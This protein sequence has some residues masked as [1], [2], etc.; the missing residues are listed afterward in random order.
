MIKSI[1][2]I[3]LN[4]FFA[5]CEEN[6]DPSL[7]SKPVAVGSDHKRGIVSTA[8]YAARKFGVHS[9]MPMYLAKK[10]CPNL[11]IVE[12]HYSLYSSV[13][14]RFMSYLKKKYPILEQVSVD[15]CYIDMSGIIND[16]NA[17]DYLADL[18]LKIYM[19]LKLKCSIGYA[20]TKFLAK[21]ASDYK[22]P[23]GLTL[24]VKDDYKKLFWPMT[25]D[26]M[27]GIGKSSAP[28]LVQLGINTIGDLANNTSKEVEDLLGINYDTFYMWA[29]GE[30]SNKVN[31]DYE[32]RK[33][34]STST[35]LLDDS[36]DVLLLK[37]TLRML[38]GD[39]AS[40][41]KSES[42]R[43]KKVVVTIRNKLFQTHSKRS[44]LEDYTDDFEKIYLKVIAIFD[45]FYKGEEVRLLG[46]GVE[47]FAAKIKDDENVSLFQVSKEEKKEDSILSNLNT[48]KTKGLFTTLGD[49]SKGS[50]K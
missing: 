29:N 31:S 17:H 35:T 2:H 36:D 21:M 30:G 44:D 13:S 45:G 48:G 24:V 33:S 40:Q 10:K 6:R 46:V 23:M 39:I 42:K 1:V 34:I 20:H 8:N 37:D 16:T 19:D 9:A 12:G 26:K 38:T 5:Q 25:I 27:W 7:K 43:A 50:K 49:I 14:H 28:K 22:K 18:Q 41:L 15:E 32:D 11:V 4:A 3:D 47:D